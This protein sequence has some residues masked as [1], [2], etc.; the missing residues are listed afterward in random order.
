MQSYKLLSWPQSD[1]EELNARRQVLFDRCT[2]LWQI[3]GTEFEPW[4]EWAISQPLQSGYGCNA[5]QSVYK[6]LEA[7]YF[8]MDEPAKQPYGAERA[9]RF[10]RAA[11]RA[12]LAASE[13]AAKRAEKSADADFAAKQDAVYE[14]FSKERDAL[15]RKLQSNAERLRPAYDAWRLERSGGVATKLPNANGA[16]QGTWYEYRSRCVRRFDRGNEEYDRWTLDAGDELGRWLV[17]WLTDSKIK[18]AIDTLAA[19]L[20]GRYAALWAAS[21]VGDQQSSYTVGFSVKK[22]DIQFGR[23]EQTSSTNFT[24][25]VPLPNYRPTHELS[26]NERVERMREWV[27]PEEHHGVFY[28]LAHPTLCVPQLTVHAFDSADRGVLIFPGGSSL[29]GIAELQ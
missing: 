15:F 24:D 4:S 27:T 17:C 8:D 19:Y 3:A 22:G 21:D 1:N 7:H 20:R 11:V 2:A 25:Y 5:R 23:F 26:E 14:A 29:N 16:A 10:D 18:Q 13:E 9:A 6:V 12:Q 28:Q